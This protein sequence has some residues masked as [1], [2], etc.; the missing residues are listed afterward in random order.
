MN[1]DLSKM[2]FK[3][4]ENFRMNQ[5]SN[6]VML[7]LQADPAK[8]DQVKNLDIFVAKLD[9][10]IERRNKDEEFVGKFVDAKERVQT[11]NFAKNN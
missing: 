1:S 8:A 9:A 6:L 11:E 10:E 5:Y 4:L 7:Q 3:F 2:D